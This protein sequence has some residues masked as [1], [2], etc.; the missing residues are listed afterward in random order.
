[1][2]TWLDPLYATPV[3]VVRRVQSGTDEYGNPAFVEQAYD[4]KCLIQQVNRSETEDG[5]TAT[6]TWT[7]FLPADTV[8]RLS[9]FD[10]IVFA[11]LG[12]FE[13]EGEPAICIRL[14]ST[15]VHHVE[16]TVHRSSA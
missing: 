11:N 6:S 8:D 14:R 7:V 15:A 2:T 9:A 16:A 5:R 10:R 3:T 12:T 13:V 1:M 4:T